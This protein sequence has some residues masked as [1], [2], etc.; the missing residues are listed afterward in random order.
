MHAFPPG[1]QIKLPQEEVWSQQQ[2]EPCY[3]AI[4]VFF[5]WAFADCL[6]GHGRLNCIHVL[7]LSHQSS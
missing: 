2:G 5:V 6:I 7:G 4:E 3:Q 1:L